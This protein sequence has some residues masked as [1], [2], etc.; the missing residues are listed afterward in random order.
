[1]ASDFTLHE[2]NPNDTIGGGGSLTSGAHPS[3]DETGPW[4]H[5]FRTSTEFN[6]SPYAVISLKRLREIA[7][8]CEFEEVLDGGDVL[9][10]RETQRHVEA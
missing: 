10:I 5:F 6:G 7:D 9:P 3:E 8:E 2:N 4:V 1:M